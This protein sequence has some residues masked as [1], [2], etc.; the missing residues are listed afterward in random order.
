MDVANAMLEEIEAAIS[1]KIVCSEESILQPEKL[2]E[3]AN[4][5]TYMS[6][7]FIV[8]HE[9]AH[10]LLAPVR[11]GKRKARREVHS[12]VL[13]DLG[14]AKEAVEATSRIGNWATEHAADRYASMIMMGC[15]RRHF[16]RGPD[17]T[18][19]WMF[20]CF[21]FHML[22]VFARAAILRRKTLDALFRHP[23]LFQRLAFCDV[24][25]ELW[26]PASR[27]S[28]VPG[29]KEINSL[30]D[31]LSIHYDVTSIRS[32]S[33]MEYFQWVNEYANLAPEV[34]TEVLRIERA[35]R[36][37]AGKGGMR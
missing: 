1:R 13:G 35:Y 36:Q 5:F 34:K 9:L 21:V 7:I 22:D 23:P 37:S 8:A 11:D 10:V 27:Y 29:F 25:F 20:L 31:Y 32:S 26:E 19:H 6:E 33:G 2:T 30:F 14:A 28:G 12:L 17:Q 18:W 15:V 24:P 4:Y 16:A 3:L